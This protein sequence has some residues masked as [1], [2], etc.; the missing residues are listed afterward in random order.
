M[1]AT[2][3]TELTTLYELET[4]ISRSDLWTSTGRWFRTEEAACAAGETTKS[5]I[6]P[7][8]RHEYYRV[9]SFNFRN[10]NDVAIEA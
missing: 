3:T 10:I 1:N 4:R 6:Y 7:E 2:R 5:M 9:T 8:A